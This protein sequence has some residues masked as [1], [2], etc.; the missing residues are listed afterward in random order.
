[1][2]LKF[3]FVFIFFSSNAHLAK[4]KYNFFLISFCPVNLRTFYKKI[5]KVIYHLVNLIDKIQK[6]IVKFKFKVNIMRLI[7]INLV[8]SIYSTLK[9][10]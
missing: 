3:C 5:F 7:Q 4:S 6:H 1:M 2:I 8:W 10:A 9:I